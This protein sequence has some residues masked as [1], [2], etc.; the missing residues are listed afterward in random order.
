[1]AGFSAQHL[2]GMEQNHPRAN[3]RK[4]LLDQ[5]SFHN[6]LIHQGP[7]QQGVKRRNVPSPVIQREQQLS[8]R[9]PGIDLEGFV[10][11]TAGDEDFQLVVQNKQRLAYRL[12]DDLC[13]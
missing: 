10:K 12:H 2:A 8:G 11:R 1:M 6:F 5:K 9:V 3:A 7:F 13:Q 4:I